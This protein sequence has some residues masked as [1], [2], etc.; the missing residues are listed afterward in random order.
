[1]LDTNKTYCGDHFARHTNIKSCTPETNT[2][3]YVNYIS[4]FKN[5]LLFVWNSDLTGLPVSLLA[6]SGSPTLRYF[7]RQQ[8]QDVPG[9]GNRTG[10]K[11]RSGKEG[12]RGGPSSIAWRENDSILGHYPRPT[13]SETVWVGPCI[14]CFNK[15]SRWFW[16][17]LVWEPLITCQNVKRVQ[18]LKIN[19]ISQV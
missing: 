19:N 10:K 13:E 14:L 12:I 18:M 4:V 3:L 2:T 17:M 11:I 16:Q 9:W 5:Y 6:K 15:P 7:D 8:R 1:M